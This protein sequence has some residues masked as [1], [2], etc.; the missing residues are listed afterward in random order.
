LNCTTSPEHLSSNAAIFPQIESNALGI[1]MKQRV[2]SRL[3]AR[4]SQPLQRL[5]V[6]V[7]VSHEL[8]E[9]AIGNRFGLPGRVPNLEQE[10]NAKD[11]DRPGL[12]P[13]G[14]VHGRHDQG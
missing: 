14:E 12:F 9:L 2:T 10:Q 7:I 5:R 8:L 4:A 6:V 11:G 1:G 13:F 3:A